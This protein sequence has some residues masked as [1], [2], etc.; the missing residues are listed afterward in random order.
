MPHW[1]SPSDRNECN[2]FKEA[3]IFYKLINIYLNDFF[4]GKQTKSKQIIVIT[5]I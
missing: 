3:K 2:M 5:G 1:L 4:A